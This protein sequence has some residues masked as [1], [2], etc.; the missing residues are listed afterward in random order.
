M[1]QSNNRILLKR[2]TTTGRTPNTTNSGNTQYIAAGE[3][4]LNLADGI[5]Y[6]SNGSTLINLSGSGGSVNTAAQY[7]FTNTIA[8]SNT[9]TV[10]DISANGTTGSAGQTL[11]SDGTKVYWSTPAGGGGGS[12]NVDSQYSWT[13]TQTFSNTIT[14]SS[15]INGT[16]NNALTANNSSY[17]NSKTEANLNVNNSV[18]SNSANN[19]SYLNSKSETN[20]NV[21]NA[22]T[23]NST[24]YINGN[25]AADLN[26]YA[27]DKATNAYSNSV[28]Y[29]DTKIGTVNTAI[30][31]NATTA[32][33]NAA[34]YADTRAGAAYTNAVSYTDGKIS[35]ANSAITAN[36]ATAYSNSV[37]YIDGKISTANSAITGNAATAYTNATSYASNATNI[38][39]GTLDQARLPY[40]MD[41][42]VTTTNNVTFANISLTGG[43][44]STLPVSSNDLVNKQYADAIA[45]GV[46]FHPAVRLVT[47]TNLTP[48]TYSNGPSSNGVG[49]T[50]TKSSS[51]SAL[52]VDSVSVAYQDRILVRSQSNTVL[53][54][55]YS[56]SNTGSGSYAWV[57]TRA[58]D[59][60]QV[61]SGTNEVDKGD[62]IYVLEGT[63]GAGTAWVEN[64]TVTTIGTDAITFVQF[65][66]K[67]LYALTEG[68]GLYYS[69][70]SAY[71]GSTAATLAVNS[72]YIATLT[73]NNASYLG[74]V[75]AAN[76][77][78]NSGAYTISGIHTYSAN[79]IMSN[80]NVIV[81]NGSFGANAYILTSNGTSM[82]WGAASSGGGVIVSDTAPATPS[83]GDLWYY[84]SDAQLY[85]YYT[86]IDGSQWVSATGGG[87]INNANNALTANNASYLGG[88]AAAGYV[89]ATSLS[90]YASLSGG[91]F[92]GS[93]AFTS[94]VSISNTRITANGSTG[95]AG[96][97]LV[98]GGPTGNVY[99]GAGGSSNAKIHAISMFIGG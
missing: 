99:W 34:S 76:Y 85:V 65:S 83:A 43:T 63:A 41:Q 68:A 32:Y 19:S 45:T 2:T 26:T 75:A 29:I 23:A 92:T 13:N 5:L 10:A 89:N 18:N 12:V 66:S 82:Y 35:T 74:T 7:T 11:T 24:T 38:S 42:N 53:N 86:D 64:S 50:L 67:A 15:T 46:N 52:T 47:N 91:T 94:N 71:D 49:A 22:L 16:A 33:T 14:F 28:S 97:A 72:S 51:Y 39:S 77:V 80:G 69:V 58:Y 20:L 1:A 6:T 59:Y 21:N 87:G 73:A 57:L 88:V 95:T 31:S 81:A 56:V 48:V 37:S 30:T 36:A 93:V 84:S 25:T 17:L 44:V 79:I 4:A 8:F 27:N 78:Q 3:L 54:G 55:V 60:D 61:G 96:Q 40:R 62:L 98:S 90:A 9:I 70:G